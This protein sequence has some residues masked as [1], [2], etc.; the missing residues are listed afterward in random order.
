MYHKKTVFIYAFV[1]RFLENCKLS[2]T[3][4]K[5]G[6]VEASELQDAENQSLKITQMRCF[7]SEYAALSADESLPCSSKLIKLRPKLDDSGVM[8][9]DGQLQYAEHFD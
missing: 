7:A 8:R 6:P 3:E 4:R 5:F 1:Y 9:C 2:Q